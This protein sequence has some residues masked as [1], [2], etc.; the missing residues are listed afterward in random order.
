[1][2]EK[3]RF[4]KRAAN[5]TKCVHVMRGKTYKFLKTVMDLTLF[6]QNT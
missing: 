4:W 1:M 5:K 3:W 2:T 6:M